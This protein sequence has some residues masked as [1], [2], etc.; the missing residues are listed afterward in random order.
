V[1]WQHL[2]LNWRQRDL[3]SALTWPLLI[4]VVVFPITL[5]TSAVAQLQF[6]LCP[7]RKEADTGAAAAK[8]SEAV[9]CRAGVWGRWQQNLGTSSSRA[10]ITHGDRSTGAAPGSPG[11]QPWADVQPHA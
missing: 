5:F 2:W 11:H 7:P 3:R 8:I 1:N 6:V 9:S 10:S 4:A